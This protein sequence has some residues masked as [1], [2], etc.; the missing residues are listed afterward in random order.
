[1]QPVHLHQHTRAACAREAA[2][3]VSA[4][5]VSVALL[6]CL[7]LSRC[8]ERVSALSLAEPRCAACGFYGQSPN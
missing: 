2:D 7:P 6:L 1:M 4:N 5:M 3:V 8:A